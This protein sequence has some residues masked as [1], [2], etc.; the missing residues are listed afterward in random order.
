[1]RFRVG[2]IFGPAGRVGF[3]L[4]VGPAG[5]FRVGKTY[6]RTPLYAFRAAAK[7]FSNSSYTPEYFFRLTIGCFH[8]IRPHLMFVTPCSE[9]SNKMLHIIFDYVFSSSDNFADLIKHNLFIIV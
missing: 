2:E 1:L 8:S 3:G 6:P 5:R 4:K 7:C 9:I